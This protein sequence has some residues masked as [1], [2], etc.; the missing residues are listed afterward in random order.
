MELA[1]VSTGTWSGDPH[2]VS[3]ADKRRKKLSDTGLFGSVTFRPVGASEVQ[4]AY[5]RSKN[6]VE[7]EFNFVNKTLIPD[8]DGVSEAY[9]GVVPASE[10]FELITDETGNIRRTLF[11]DNLR[12]F[13]GDNKVNV[14]I[15]AT[16]EDPVG[17]QRFA[18]LNNGV[19]LV[20][21]EL[22]VVKN[23]FTVRD[24][25]IVNGCQT[26]HV[27]FNL[28]GRLGDEIFIPLK[29]VATTDEK[30]ISSIIV[31]T[32]RQTEVTAD[33]LISRGKFQEQ[34]EALYGA[35]PDKKKL[36]YERRSKQYAAVSGIEKVRIIGKSQ[37]IR[38]FA[39]MF[40]DEAHKSTRYYSDLYNLIGAKIFND[41][42]KKEPYYVAAYGF[43]K[44]E[45]LWRN[46]LI[47]VYYK[48]AR[49]QLL[50]AL[51]YVVKGA[52]MPD[53]TANKISRYADDIAEI[54][55]SDTEAVAAFKKAIE[56]V[57]AAVGGASLSRD[58][59][60]TQSFTDAVKAAANKLGPSRGSAH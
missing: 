25:Q 4:K 5:E 28:K 33:D 38:S 48:P 23:R 2:L 39:A 18:V 6:S 60:K 17:Q 57:D 58:L 9:L 44:L 34:L 11:Y 41:K 16:L 47:P 20:A 37:Q 27:L 52:S 59:V 29:V 21:R 32:N 12:D 8:I 30:I 7:V 54:L 19:T 26:S 14:E 46:G 51:R 1:Y 10:Y 24:Y 40:L 55:W 56:A 42:H 49:F 43:Y 53:L 13:Q 3:R 45:Y 15:K 35:Y 31:A 36:Y 50:M 22:R